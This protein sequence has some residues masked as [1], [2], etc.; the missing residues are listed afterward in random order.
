MHNYYKFLDHV[1]CHKVALCPKMPSCLT[2]NDLGE[3]SSKMTV[4][5]S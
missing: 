4:S 3:I 5:V 2:T 1:L